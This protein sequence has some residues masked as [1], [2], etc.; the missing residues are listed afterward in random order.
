MF[1]KVKDPRNPK[2]KKHQIA[3]LLMYSLLLFVFIFRSRRATSKELAKSQ[4]HENM[5]ILF[6]E[7]KSI[8]HRDTIGKL[9]EKLTLMILRPFMWQ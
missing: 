3:F 4:F 8:P 2:K 5:L 6:P 9:L 1:K 7:F